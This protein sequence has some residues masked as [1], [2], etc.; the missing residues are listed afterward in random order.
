MEPLGGGG[1]GGVKHGHFHQFDIPVQEY[2]IAM[3]T[4]QMGV[5]T[6]RDHVGSC[7]TIITRQ[8]NRSIVDF[9]SR[10]KGEIDPPK[11]LNF[12][13]YSLTM[14]YSKLGGDCGSMPPLG[15]NAQ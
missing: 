10:Q 12:G 7:N 14:F 4:I 8:R 15:P 3:T 11:K 5:E 1:E 9:T 13:Q 6:P 2:V